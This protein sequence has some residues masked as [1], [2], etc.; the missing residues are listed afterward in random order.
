[1][2]RAEHDGNNLMSAKKGTGSSPSYE[3]PPGN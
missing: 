2:D 3:P 1:M